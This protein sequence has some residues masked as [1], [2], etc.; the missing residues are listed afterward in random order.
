MN[1]RF[2]GIDGGGSTSRLGVY[3]ENGTRLACVTGG[4]TNRYTVG[5]ETACT[6]LRMLIQK[7]R[8]VGGI[9]IRECTAGC[10]AS[11]GMSEEAEKESF[12]SFFLG[13][14]IRVPVYLCNDAFAALAGG[15]GKK[16]GIIVVSG[17]GSIAAGIDMQGNTARTGG[18]GHL[19]SDEGSGF[20]I[21]L[22]GIRAAAAAYE[23]RGPATVLLSLL[24]AHYKVNTIRELFPFLY[25]RFD[26]SKIAS[27]A[28]S[29]FAA[30]R[31][32]DAAAR[33]ILH[34]AAHDLS[35]LARSVYN[36]L[37]TESFVELVFSGGVLSNEPVFAR[38]VAA[39]ITDALPHVR[40]IHRRFDAVTGAC[41]LAGLQLA[42]AGDQTN[43][44]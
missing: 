2:F 9:D 11:A 41:I 16:E 15:T 1:T 35:A 14:N 18:L 26:K 44:C 43:H 19:I 30:A 25:T 5:F 24:F 12:R 20:R 4:A 7:M 39:Y 42:D 17:T 10:F 31:Q 13:E 6:N 21:G 38:Q 23:R 36:S 3:D 34:T 32:R 37:F 33:A 27:F 8:A 40:I 28:P 22:D 29:V